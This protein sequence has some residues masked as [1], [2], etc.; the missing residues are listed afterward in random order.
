MVF[1]FTT[2][3]NEVYLFTLSGVSRVHLSMDL[4]PLS[5]QPRAALS[6]L[7]VLQARPCSAL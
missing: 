4:P 5:E 1:E 3:S 2:T 7:S 6:E